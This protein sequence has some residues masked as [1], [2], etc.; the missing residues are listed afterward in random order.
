MKGRILWEAV[1]PWFFYEL[2]ASF[3]YL[4]YG[5]FFGEMGSM[6]IAALFVLPILIPVYCYRMRKKEIING[7]EGSSNL[8]RLRAAVFLKLALFAVSTCLF[9]NFLL[10]VLGLFQIANSYQSVNEKLFGSALWFQLLFIGAVAPFVEELIYRGLLFGTLR[11]SY[12]FLPS[13]LLSALFFGI[14]HGNLLQGIYA[15]ILGVLLAFIYEKNGLM[16]AVW[17]HV[18]ANLTSIVMNWLG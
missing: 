4:L 8:K 3:V 16:A 10:Y 2:I 5:W 12:A 11:T 9:L 7:I 1:W 15:A 17:F 18:W 14:A 6:L 13:M